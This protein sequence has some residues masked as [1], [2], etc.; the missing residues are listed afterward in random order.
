M[1]V[2]LHV[3]EAVY[4][5]RDHSDPAVDVLEFRVRIPDGAAVRD[6]TGKAGIQCYRHGQAGED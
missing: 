4:Y 6:A 2:G 1:L 5:V 3:R